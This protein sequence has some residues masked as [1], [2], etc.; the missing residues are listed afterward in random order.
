MMKMKCLKTPKKEAEKIRKKLAERKILNRDKKTI[1]G[2]ENVFFPLKK[3]IDK[4]LIKEICSEEVEIVEK[5][6]EPKTNKPRSLKEALKDKF[7]EE[8][9]EKLVTSFNIVGDIATLEIPEELREKE[10]EIGK[11]IM[12]VHP[13]VKTVCRRENKTKGR[14][15]IRKVHPIAGEEK[16]ETIYKEHGIKIKLD[17]NK[18]YFNP[19]LSHEREIIENKVKKGEKIGYLFAGVG[20]FALVIAKKN[21]DVEITAVEL[22]PEAY[23]YLEEN[24]DLNNFTG[25]IKPINEDVKKLKGYNFERVIMTMPIYSEEFLNSVL[26]NISNE[27][28]IHYYSL[29]EEPDYYEKPMKELKKHIDNFEVLDKREVLNYAPGKKEVVIDIKIKD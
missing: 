12:K 5:E 7:N 23:K 16:T 20:P 14:Y 19:R 2:K 3:E 21:P 29:G 6:T 9:K 11:A 28:I 1:T 15:R 10:R 18:T 22:N 13:S 25:I 17:L 24:I 4:E 26:K 8:E 27:A